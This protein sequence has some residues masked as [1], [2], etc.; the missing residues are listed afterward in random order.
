MLVSLVKN[1]ENNPTSVNVIDEVYL[2]NTAVNT[3]HTTPQ[4]WAIWSVVPEHIAKYGK[5]VEAE[6]KADAAN[7]AAE[8]ASANTTDATELAKLEAEVEKIK[9]E[10]EVII[11]QTED[12][13][14]NTAEGIVAEVEGVVEDVE[15]HVNNW[16]KKHKKK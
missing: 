9:S 16:K 15:N 7:V 2:P 5:K 14:A 13:V 6:V 3:G 10:A 1:L 4:G 11:G 8:V 12:A